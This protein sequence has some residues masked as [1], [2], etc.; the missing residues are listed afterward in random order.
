MKKKVLVTA[1]GTVTAT[2]VVR[3]LKKTGNYYIIGADIN[4]QHEIATSLDV[5]EY[6]VFPLATASTYLE[7]AIAFCKEHKVDYYFAVIDKEVVKISEARDK[8]E[9]VGTKLCVVNYDFAKACHFKDRFGE[10]IRENLPEVAIKEYKSFSEAQTAEYPLFIKP[11]EGV[12]SAGCRRIDS[13]KEL[14]A[15]VKEE[16][17]GSEY[18]LQDFVE[19]T[20]ITVDCLRNRKT[21][22][23][24][25]IQRRELLRNSNGCGIAVEIF[26]ND[27]LE[28]ICDTLM[29]KLDLN[30]VVNM[31]FF[32]TDKGYRIIEINPRF[33]AGTLYS[34][35][36]GG[37]TV[38]NAIHIAEGEPCEYGKI[39]VGAQFAERYEPYRMN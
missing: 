39:E 13:F 7:F 8:F 27:E 9:E 26:H 24:L 28:R 22:Q 21:G 10:W 34:C 15:S 25:Q 19:G 4:K 37:N 3:Q 29:E 35:M 16:E 1:I 33:S 20:N 38:L 17:L 32:E 11:S 5:D 18:I 6:Q 31:E 12:A 30:G 36:S 23:K 2:A 14:E